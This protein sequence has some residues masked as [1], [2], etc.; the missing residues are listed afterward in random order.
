MDRD[1]RTK[2]RNGQK[3]R[4]LT[5]WNWLSKSVKFISDSGPTDLGLLPL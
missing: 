1:Q 4:S 2:L 3:N 5:L